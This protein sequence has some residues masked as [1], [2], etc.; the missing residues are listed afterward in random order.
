MQTT[1][2]PIQKAIVEPAIA[3]QFGDQNPTEIRYGWCPFG[4]I[5]LMGPTGCVNYAVQPAMIGDP[6]VENPYFRMLPMKQ[7]IPFPTFQH[8][9]PGL[10]PDKR[11]NLG[12][13]TAISTLR[14]I[15]ALEAVLTVNAWY[16]GWG[17]TVL[18]SLQGLD[19]DMAY[20]IFAV[21]QPLAY[22]LGQMANELSFG[23]E[24]RIDS[25]TP[26]R[27]IDL[28]DYV[29]EP[30]RN[31]YER[32][33]ARELAR[34]MA[35]GAETAVA[36]AETILNETVT[37]LTTRF[38]GGTGKSGPDSLDKRLA[39]EL[40]MT[41][42]SV[43]AKEVPAQNNDVL[44][45]KVDKIIEY[46]EKRELQDE[47]ER[48]KRELAEARGINGNTMKAPVEVCGRPKADNTPCQTPT[49]NGEPCHRHVESPEE[50]VEG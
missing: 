29:V 20:R 14:T 13:A 19:Q 11:D 27:F 16:A 18:N 7:L 31:D 30:L 15:S 45:M 48:L 41:L 46:N 47:N 3:Q 32:E 42:P 12:H 39:A 38:A 43:L 2:L 10:D 1:A 50:T 40:G 36:K 4:D 44:E 24:A 33:I 28:P 6:P 34:E 8:T 21:V 9:E 5:N 17:F 22:P 26:I 49:K 37:S 25:E 35:G 23:A